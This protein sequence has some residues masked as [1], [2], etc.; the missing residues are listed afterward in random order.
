[1]R[2]IRCNDDRHRI[3]PPQP[4][5]S[6]GPSLG[7]VQKTHFRSCSI[8]LA[9]RYD[10]ILVMRQNR[11]TSTT[12]GLSLSLYCK[13]IPTR[14]LKKRKKDKK[15]DTRAHTPTH[16]K[17]PENSSRCHWLLVLQLLTAQGS[18]LTPMQRAHSLGAGP[19]EENMCLR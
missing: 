9:L 5:S 8:Y 7:Y 18:R 16:M 12:G 11:R 15:T 10:T 14:G 1:M 6:L 2:L 17:G 19:Q 4:H 3:A 13:P